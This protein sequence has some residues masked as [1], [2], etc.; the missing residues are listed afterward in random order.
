VLR[1]GRR[2]S[3]PT[4]VLHARGRDD[5]DAARV[6]VVASRRV[7]TAVRRNRA[8]R[9]LR[10]AVSGVPLPRGVDVVLVA[11]AS[12]P[13]ASSRDVEEQVRSTVEQMF[14]SVGSVP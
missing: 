13:D 10:A 11:R 5:D 6:A 4:V 1:R 2:A 14:G 3:S 8:K 12:T 9:V 7:G